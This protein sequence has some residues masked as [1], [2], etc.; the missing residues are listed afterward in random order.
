MPL[1][2]LLCSIDQLEE[3]VNIGEITFRQAFEKDNNPEDF[4]TY[5]DNAFSQKTISQELK[6][7]NSSFYFVYKAELLVGYFKLNEYQ[8]QNEIKDAHGMELERIYVLDQFQNQG[9]G[10]H[11]LD[12]VKQIGLQK[13]KS[14]LWLGVWQENHNAIRFYEKHGFV[15][16]DTHPYYIGNDKQTDWLMRLD[17]V[18]FSS[19]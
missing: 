4:K 8:A 3:L 5:M 10:I 18:P 7:P 6:N 17:L 15:K 16:F 12:E 2:Y 1:N 19:S 11:I 14:Y 13:D 9:I